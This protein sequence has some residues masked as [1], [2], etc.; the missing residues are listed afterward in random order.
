MKVEKDLFDANA[1]LARFCRVYMQTKVDM[2]IRPSEMG[3][4]N[5]LC[6]VAGPHT[7]VSLA[8]SLGVSRPMIAAHLNAL[9]KHGLIARVPSPE[10]GRSFYI[11]PSKRGK[12]LFERVGNLEKERLYEIQSK[13]GQQQFE[14][15]MEIVVQINQI[16]DT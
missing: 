5:V 2:P 1:Q 9:V 15:F 8:D 14:N 3:V 12:D 16:L 7:P 10:D 11:M 4:L 13:L 6:T